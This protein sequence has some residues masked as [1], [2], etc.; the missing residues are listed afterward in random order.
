MSFCWRDATDTQSLTMRDVSR[1][2][3]VAW[4]QTRR[5]E[6]LGQEV[7]RDWGLCRR[8]GLCRIAK[9]EQNEAA[10]G[11][12]LPWEEGWGADLPRQEGALR[13]GFDWIGTEAMGDLP[14]SFTLDEHLLRARRQTA[15][16]RRSSCSGAAGT[17][18]SAVSV[19]SWVCTAP[20]MK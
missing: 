5:R 19:L 7:P 3:R 11:E 14:S 15:Q 1:T 17:N 20:S 13:P 18:L 8:E 10:E 12:N 9:G 4:I 16:A 2:P 6:L